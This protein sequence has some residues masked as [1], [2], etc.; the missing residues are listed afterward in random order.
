M[1]EDGKDGHV[2]GC[3]IWSAGE[4]L[5]LLDHVVVAEV[6]PQGHP[7]PQLAEEDV[8]VVGVDHR[9]RASRQHLALE[10]LIVND[11]DAT[12]WLGFHPVAV[13]GRGFG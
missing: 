6:P 8:Q 12:A 9:T 1:G 10:I 7:E 4:P 13:V 11:K 2:A 5:H 3:V